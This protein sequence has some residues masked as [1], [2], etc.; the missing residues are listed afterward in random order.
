MRR[1]IIQFVRIIFEIFTNIVTCL[2]VVL[3]IIVIVV[4]IE[5]CFTLFHQA[6]AEF[7][8]YYLHHIKTDKEI[9]LVLEFDIF[10]IYNFPIQSPLISQS[11][12]FKTH[13][14]LLIDIK[15]MAP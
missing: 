15:K 10:I 2:M 14:E 8:F 6:V 3:H 5:M 4:P 11:L 13:V 7:P 1:H 12:F 9:F